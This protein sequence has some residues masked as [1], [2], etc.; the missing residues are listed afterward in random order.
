MK[1]QTCYF[2]NSTLDEISTCKACKDKYGLDYVYTGYIDVNHNGNHN[3]DLK[4]LSSTIGL[5][6]NQIYYNVIFKFLNYNTLTSIN[7][8][9]IYGD[10]K[11]ILTLPGYPFAPANL[12]TKLKLYVLLS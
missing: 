1:T 5:Y 7:E 2:C 8:T 10:G 12:K 3:D 11:L 4:L 9:I 6:I